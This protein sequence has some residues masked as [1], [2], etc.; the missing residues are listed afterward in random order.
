MDAY[1]VLG[2][3]LDADE[4]TIKR[5]YAALIKQYRPETHPADF[6]RVRDAY[7]EALY[8]WREN[9]QWQA[10][11]EPVEHAASRTEN[12]E[13]SSEPASAPDTETVQL[14]HIETSQDPAPD[15]V[16]LLLQE[17]TSHGSEQARLQSY[18]AQMAALL[19]WP[20]DQQI[21]FEYALRYWLLFTDDPALLIFRAAD[22]RYDWSSNSMEIVSLYGSEA[23]SRFYVLK[24]LAELYVQARRKN[25][26]FLQ[27]EDSAPERKRIFPAN[28]FHTGQAKELCENWRR[29]C[30]A[31]DYAK[32]AQRMSPTDDSARQFYWVDIAFG[33][34]MGAL[35]WLFTRI[36][37][38]RYAVTFGILSGVVSALVPVLTRNVL[39]ASFP[40]SAWIE[41]IRSWRRTIKVNKTLDL[42][43][44]IVLTMLGLGLYGAIA[45]G[46]I[47]MPLIYV[48]ALVGVT[49]ILFGF[50]KALA[51]VEATIAKAVVNI[52]HLVELLSGKR[53]GQQA[54]SPGQVAKAVLRGMKQKLKA[55]WQR[56]RSATY[57]WIF[58]WVLVAQLIRAFSSH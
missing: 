25:N 3:D 56:A 33:F 16:Q 29:D 4:R 18:H 11:P 5:A 24:K 38:E 14:T 54:L 6:A 21:N 32:L 36:E 8:Y 2:I 57:W 13:G 7:E 51:I 20:L 37:Y 22:E 15:P 43:L 9:L 45:N 46:M 23:G 28:H 44:W 52:W 49:F 48:I 17:I 41:K 39:T 35:V 40:G 34:S 31:A 1:E 30:K 47:P 27:F 50:Y 19:E 42:Y 55:S 12:A 58:I 10:D 26:P 53:N